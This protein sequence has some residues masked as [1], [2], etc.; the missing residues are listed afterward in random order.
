MVTERIDLATVENT[1]QRIESTDSLAVEPVI[2][3]NATDPSIL[4]PP[5]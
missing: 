3:R 1:W 4:K 5:R 2:I